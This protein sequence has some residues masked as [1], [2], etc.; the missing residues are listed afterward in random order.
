MNGGYHRGNHA[1]RGVWLH[2]QTRPERC[3]AS[4]FVGLIGVL[5]ASLVGIFVQLPLLVG[6]STV[7]AVLFTGS[8]VRPQPRGQQPRGDRRSGDFAGRQRVPRR[9]QLVSGGAAA[10]RVR[11]AAVATLDVDGVGSRY[12][13]RRAATF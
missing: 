8:G 3:A 12:W 2:H 7:A 9:H 6:I 4:L 10:V 5:V 1:R 11:P 13:R